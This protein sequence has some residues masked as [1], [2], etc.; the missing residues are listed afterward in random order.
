[1]EKNKE[2]FKGYSKQIGC[3]YADYFCRPL[4][5]PKIH[6]RNIGRVTI[7]RVKELTGTKLVFNSPKAFESMVRTFTIGI[8]ACTTSLV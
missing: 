4:Q 2:K 8:G 5:C 6:R 1:M 3:K 7:L